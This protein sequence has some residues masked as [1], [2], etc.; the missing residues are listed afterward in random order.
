MRKVFLGAA[1]ALALMVSAPAAAAEF[2]TFDFTALTPGT[3]I[4]SHN[5]SFILKLDGSSL[6]LA[7]VDFSV[8]STVFD[9]TNTG[10]LLDFYQNIG[11]TFF[12]VEFGASGFDDFDLRLDF[13]DP[14]DPTTF[15]PIDF[16]YTTVG[17]DNVAFAF[18]QNLTVT[19][20]RTSSSIP[21]SSTWALMLLGF[22]CAGMAIR[23]R[24]RQSR[25]LAKV[26]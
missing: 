14:L 10:T 8:G 24:R 25:N 23:Y 4:T 2:Y 17:Y 11:G 13:A 20:I 5:G 12:G 26:G 6:T 16:W 22:G 19:L 1:S 3:P 21:E 9:T 15:S 7:A 18:D